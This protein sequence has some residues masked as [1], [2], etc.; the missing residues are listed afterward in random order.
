MKLR[1]IEIANFRKFRT[2][3]SITGFVDGLNIVVEPN[4]A[5]KSTLLEAL[6]AALFIRHSAKSELVRSYCP[7]GDDVAPKVGLSFEIGLDSWRLDKQFLKAPSIALSGPG[8]RIESDAAEDRLQSLL[9]FDK[10]NNRGS[11]PESRGALGLLW[12][13]QASALAVEAPGQLVRDN[14][15]NALEAEVGAVLGGRRFELVRARVEDSYAALRTA[16]SGKP[17]GRLAEAESSAGEARDRRDAAEA[18]LRSYEQALAAL[19]QARTQKRLLE[20]ELDDPEQASLRQ[21]LADDLKLAESAQLRLTAAEARHAE[22]EGQLK[23]IEQAIAALER[24]DAAQRTAADALAKASAALL[25]HQADHDAAV[26]TEADRRTA[27]SELRQ[28]RHVAEQAATLARQVLARNERQR[29]TAR[30]RTQLA[31]V[32]AL[33]QALVAK[34]AL[35]SCALT[36]QDVEQLATLDRKV[37]ETRTLRDAGAVAVE[38]AITGDHPLAI[39]GAAVQVGRHDVLQPTEITI[40]AVARLSITPPATVGRS[41]A[42]AYEAA[43]EAY[44]NR[45]EQLDIESYA[46]A[47]TRLSSAQ[48][49]RQEVAGLKRQIEALCPGDPT[50][51]LAPGAPALKLFLAQ[52]AAETNDGEPDP[53]LSVL[54]KAFDAAC[55]AEQ[56]AAGQYENAQQS[57]HRAETRLVQLKAEAAAA[58]RE[59]ATATGQVEVLEAQ[60]NRAGLDAQLQAAREEFARRLEALEQAKRAAQALDIDRIRRSIANQ[61]QAQARAHEERLG[62]VARIAS[63]EATIAS[64]GP[65]GLA[66]LAA[67]AREIEEAALAHHARLERE[68]DALALLRT[69]LR[70]AGEAAARTFLGPVTRRAARYVE[71]ILPGSDLLF[72]KD[73]ELSAIRRDGVDETCGDLSR[74]T[75]EQLAVLT[76]LAFADLLLDKNAPVSLILDDPLVYSDDGRLEAMTE[77]LEE[78]SQRMQVILLT[79]RAKAFR[80]VTANRILLE[81]LAA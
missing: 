78:A 65:K 40:G 2:P 48:A 64:E 24:A 26:A 28:K 81:G 21:K 7:F 61:D 9:G 11:D 57:L 63:L 53:D 71:R 34:Q 56:A 19:E 70:E 50:L 66:G 3:L 46:A 20:R 54:T 23:T 30:A 22:G 6:R 52:A 41:A 37:T 32:E 75:Q 16:R 36:A 38:I 68:A 33:E 44:R 39:N 8:G 49:A 60:H 77:L 1:S 15:R 10:G 72:G 58:E 29:A 47:V 51:D 45:L 73:M 17:T 55:E 42:A 43:A 12:V 5:G 69:T 62:L 76:R 25:A 67:E 59:A 74:G 31:E 79:C 13:G 80:H 27:L 4:E 14:I 18:Q 35:A